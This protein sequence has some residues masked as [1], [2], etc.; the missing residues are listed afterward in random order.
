MINWF[1]Q[2]YKQ[3]TQQVI[4]KF[5]SKRVQDHATYLPV[6][7]EKGS[8]NLSCF[9]FSHWSNVICSL[10][11]QSKVRLWE[12]RSICQTK[13][14][15]HWIYGKTEQWCRSWCSSWSTSTAAATATSR[16][17]LSCMLTE[18]YICYYV[19]WRMSCQRLINSR[20][21]MR[22]QDCVLQWMWFWVSKAWFEVTGKP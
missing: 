22:L 4:N 6:N 5:S 1:C 12:T 18:K 10:I 15:E 19:L 2:N 3:K 14:S 17:V 7:S 9:L 21:F 13:Y 16:V 8:R 20:V 11:D